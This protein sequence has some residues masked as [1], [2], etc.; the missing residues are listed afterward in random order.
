[1]LGEGG[2]VGRGRQGYLEGRGRA[3]IFE[4]HTA[5][6][7]HARL[8]AQAACEAAEAAAQRHG[9][10]ASHLK[11]LVLDLPDALAAQAVRLGHLLQQQPEKKGVRCWVSSKGV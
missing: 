9:S 4:C 2:L 3:G 7:Q 6:G 5:T 1:M 11:R 8:E 10:K